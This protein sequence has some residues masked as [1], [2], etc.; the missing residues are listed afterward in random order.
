VLIF[1]RNDPVV[2]ASLRPPATVCKPS[3]LDCLIQH[4]DNYLPRLFAFDLDAMFL[5]FVFVRFTIRDLF[6]TFAVVFEAGSVSFPS[7]VASSN[8]AVISS[9]LGR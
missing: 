1:S 6:P 3:G 5:P 4:I 7:I 8:E 9:S 2:Y